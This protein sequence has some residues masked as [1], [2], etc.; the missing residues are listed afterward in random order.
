[1]AT[2]KKTIFKGIRLLAICLPLLFIGPTI[3]NSSFKNQN[4][5]FYY[6]ILILGIACCMIAMYLM[7]RGLSIMTK[8]IFND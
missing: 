1:M 5:D 3:I 7:F 2:D 6:P 8:G 4:N